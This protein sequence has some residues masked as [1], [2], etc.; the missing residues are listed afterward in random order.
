MIEHDVLERV[1]AGATSGGA[2]FAE[3]YAED[4]RSTSAGLDDGRIEQ[5][6]SGRD[7]G[8]GI[9]VIAGDTTG[10]AY[11]SDLSEAGLRAAADAAAAAAARGGGGVAAVGLVQSDRHRPNA[12]AGDPDS[13]D[14]ARKVELLTRMDEAARRTSSER[15]RARGSSSSARGSMRTSP[16]MR[17]RDCSRSRRKIRTR[18]FGCG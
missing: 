17:A 11:T 2:D 3:V 7:R 13:I 4:K 1:L 15:C 8:A 9:R 18:R 10:F 12:G 6:T 16:W 14:K 5:V